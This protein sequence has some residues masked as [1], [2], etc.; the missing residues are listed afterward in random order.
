M[1]VVLHME[2]RTP[3]MSWKEF[4]TSKPAYSIAIDGYVSTATLFDEEGPR[5]NLNHHEDCDRLA[6]RATCAQA[7]MYAR[8]GLADGFRLP[9]GRVQMDVFANDCDQDVCTAY[10]VLDQCP[11][12]EMV[13]NPRLN[14]L[15]HAED[16]MDSTA[17]AYPFPIDAQILR[18]LAWVFQPYTNF[19]LSGGLARRDSHEFES[20]VRDVLLRIKEHIV[21]GGHEIDLSIAYDVIGGGD[22]WE[23]VREYGAQAR[24]A[25]FARGTK[26]FVSVQDRPDGTKTYS[27]G[28]M[29]P[30]I[31]SFRIPQIL[32]A[33]NQAEGC[34]GTDMWGGG[35]TIGGSPR[36]SGS[37]LAPDEVARIINERIAHTRG[38]LS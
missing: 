30:L 35:N 28:R 26:A 13:F 20:I 3:P 8:Q 17:G 12:A 7:L 23:M 1:P 25:M 24:T 27:V 21:S 31:R 38:I 18:E 2:P 6:T 37:R 4:C 14:R 5:L 33:L 34:V 22:G 11:L 15:V 16:M 29:S 10:F 32:T 9:N 36:V 19:R